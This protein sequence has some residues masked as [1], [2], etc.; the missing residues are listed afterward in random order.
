[1]QSSSGMKKDEFK[2]T[3]NIHGK[4]DLNE[5]ELR[6]EYVEKIKRIEKANKKPVL[7]KNID[8]LFVDE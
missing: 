6:P 2:R 8:D 4:K 5:P 7:I 1:M 3:S